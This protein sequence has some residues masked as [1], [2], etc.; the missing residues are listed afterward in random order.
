MKIPIVA[1]V[2]TNADPDNIDYVIPGN[3]DALRSI[4]LYKSYFFLII[5]DA[6][7]YQEKKKSVD[8]EE[9]KKEN[10]SKEQK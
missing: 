9:S 4:N 10:D 8:E 1:I 5:N 2:D 3:D 7:Q 6:L